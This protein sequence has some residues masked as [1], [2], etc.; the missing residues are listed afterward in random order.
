MKRWLRV[1]WL[2][3]VI[4]GS[5]VPIGH[6][7]RVSEG[8]LLP[9][10]EWPPDG[11]AEIAWTAV[12]TCAIASSLL[13]LLPATKPYSNRHSQT[14]VCAAFFVLAWMWSVAKEQW[15]IS[16]SVPIFSALLLALGAGS[17]VR[18]I[19]RRFIKDP[20]ARD[21]ICFWLFAAILMSSFI[22]F[23]SGSSGAAD[24]MFAFARDT[25][26]LSPYAAEFAVVITRKTLHFTVYGLLAWFTYKAARAGDASLNGSVAIALAFALVHSIFDE[27]RQ[28]LTLGRTGS[29]WDV[30]LDLAGML[31][32][33]SISIRRERKAPT[34]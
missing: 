6:W 8:M 7:I 11:V 27:T 25:L 22:A 30:L 34:S 17:L 9:N 2:P 31:T 10:G 26:G 33:L 12:I 23:F 29:P 24:P 13:A 3:L 15:A 16:V 5:A 20:L 4:A 1:V 18:I 19:S 32:F 14:I 28:S 21:Q